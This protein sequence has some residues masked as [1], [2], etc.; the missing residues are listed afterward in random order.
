MVGVVN[1][2]RQRVFLIDEKGNISSGFP[3][4]GSTSFSIGKLTDRPGF[5]LLVGSG[6]RFLYNY[7]I[8][9]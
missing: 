7:R 9:K 4:K 2:P 5:N 1:I 8:N 3:L 6:D